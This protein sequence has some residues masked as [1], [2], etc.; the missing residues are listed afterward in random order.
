M[1]HTEIIAVS[2][3][4]NRKHCKAHCGQKVPD[5]HFKPGGIQ[6]QAP[7]V[8]Q[9]PRM[10]TPQITHQPIN[11]ITHQPINLRKHNNFFF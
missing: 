6:K 4:M 10:T 5:L 9:N 3:E 11:Q 7:G 1:P 2:S 8:K